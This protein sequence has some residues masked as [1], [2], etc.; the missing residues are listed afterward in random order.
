M[1]KRYI[2]SYLLRR[3]RDAFFARDF[4]RLRQWQAAFRLAVTL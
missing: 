3:M 4:A 1:S 2:C